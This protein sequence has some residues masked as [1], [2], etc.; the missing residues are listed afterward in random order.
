MFKKIKS[1]MG[2]KSEDDAEKRQVTLKDD[3]PKKKESSDKDKM[4]KSTKKRDETEEER[5]ERK[6]RE[7]REKGDGEFQLVRFVS[8]DWMMAVLVDGLDVNIA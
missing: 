8:D 6:E 5:R 3:R 2:K 7:R 4:R 1:N